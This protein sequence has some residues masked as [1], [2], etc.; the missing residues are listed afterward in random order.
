[1]ASTSPD[2]RSN[3]EPRRQLS[4]TQS[5]NN[6]SAYAVSPLAQ[7]AIATDLEE[8]PDKDLEEL[9]D[10]EDS[11]TS[12][13]SGS[14]TLRP[15]PSRRSQGG[16]DHSMVGSYRR[17]SFTSGGG[18]RATCV[19]SLRSASRPPTRSERHEARREERSLLRDNNIIPPKHPQKGD[20]KTL[21]RRISQAIPHVGIPGG[22]R[23]IVPVDEE[24]NEENEDSRTALPET[25]PLLGNPKLPYGGQDSPRN[26]EKRWEQA[27]MEGRIKTTWQREAKVIARYSGPLI[28]TFLLQYSLTVA[29][30]FTVGHIGK[31]EL[32]AVSLASMTAN[33]TGY[34]IY[35]GLATSLDTLCSQAYGSGKKKLV[36]LQLQRMVYFLWLITVPIAIIWLSAEQIL[37]RIVPEADVARLAGLYLKIV[38]IGAPGYAAFESGK[39]YL[40]AQGLFSASLYVL[41]ICAPLN[42][43]MNWLFVWVNSFLLLA[44]AFHRDPSCLLSLIAIQVGVH[45]RSHRGRRYRQPLTLAALPLRSFRR[46]SSL[47][48]GFYPPC[49]SQ[50]GTDDPPCSAR[51]NSGRS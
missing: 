20:S 12:S 43:L 49:F 16:S 13:D 24:T 50:L 42:V 48:A 47:L 38:L 14:S 22:N 1:M 30:I 21:G 15:V 7:A 37:V 27:V 31:E 11:D 25:T 10:G 26:L 39:R 4:Q 17:P 40:Q 19:S 35:Q 6:S 36:G 34:A 46:W 9:Q 3:R 5:Y 18:A 29:S 8:A 41:L 23:K 51:P 33:I 28:L 44:S 45:W 32:G 2:P